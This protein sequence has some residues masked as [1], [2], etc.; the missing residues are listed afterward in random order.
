[1][2]KVASLA[3]GEK[4][5]SEDARLKNA[6]GELKCIATIKKQTLT[7]DYD[8]YTKTY[9]LLLGTRSTYRFSIELDGSIKYN[10]PA[11]RD[12]ITEGF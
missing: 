6:F 8:Q 12:W 11:T 5:L 2:A 9:H 4:M 3:Q 7:L 10:L 1:M